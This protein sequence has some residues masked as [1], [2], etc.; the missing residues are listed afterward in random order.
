MSDVDKIVDAAKDFAC[1]IYR[2]MPG[3]LIPT[4]ASA[5]LRFV[6]DG[7]C[8]DPP[9]DPANLPPPPASGFSGGQCKC[10]LYEVNI[11]F[12]KSDYPD[13]TSRT[14]S[15]VFGEVGG[16]TV[17]VLGREQSLQILCRGREA[18]GCQPE[19]VAR[20]AFVNANYPTV[21]FVEYAIESIYRIDG[22]ADNC[23]DPPASFPPGTIPPGGFTSPP[24]AINFNDNTTNN[25]TFN[26]TPPTIPNLKNFIPP[27]I[28]NF[29]SLKGEFKIPI[30]FNFNGSVNFGGGDGT[31]YNQGDRDII[32]NISNNTSTT[33][34][35]VSEIKNTTSNTSTKIENFYNTY[36]NDRDKD[37]N[38]PPKPGDFD[39][40]GSPVLPGEHPS[41]RLAFVE[42]ILSKIPGNAKTQSG[43]GA[44][45]VIYAGW[46]EFTRVGKN[47]PREPIHFQKNCFL[48]PKGVDGYAFTL[49]DGYEGTAIAIKNK[50]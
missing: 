23:G 41:E 12:R 49:Y 6:W 27:I 25:Y 39:P 35:N 5:L 16:L 24:T 9:R 26:F 47:L 20:N 18:E 11:R 7:F 36:G 33:N 31:S 29:N 28:I 37:N 44:P 10:A 1:G 8:G 3:A 19:I 46:F 48:A 17:S 32:N 50:E 30:T 21:E 15:R 4:P 2:N 45:N 14:Y 38:K 43:D 34:N 22:G 42:V 13:I 40:P